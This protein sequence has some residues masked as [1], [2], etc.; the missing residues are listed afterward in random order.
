MPHR[1]T[2][3]TDRAAIVNRVL[4]YIEGWFEADV[5]RMERALHRELCK[6][7]LGRDPTGR[8]ELNTITASQMIDWTAEGVGTTRVPEG[9]DPRIQVQ[10]EDIHDTIAN[11]TVR[12]S[13]YR[14]YLQL[15]RTEG[16]WKIANALW[17]R[18]QEGIP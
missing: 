16:G 13:V 4:A 8:D 14:E 9:G 11:V 18:T 17:Q 3:E 6:R 15:V 12:S 2:A 7:S 5:A 10:V 1:T